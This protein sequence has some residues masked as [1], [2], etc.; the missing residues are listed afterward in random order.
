MSGS[1]PG[2]HTGSLSCQT[3]L[4]TRYWGR[5][6]GK[7]AGVRLTALGPY[8]LGMPANWVRVLGAENDSGVQ[9]ERRGARLGVAV[10]QA[11]E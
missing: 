7:R 2:L 4:Q 8:L 3:G 1:E 5:G 11:L 6:E 9:V 10:E